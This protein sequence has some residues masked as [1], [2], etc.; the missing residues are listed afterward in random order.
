MPRILNWKW[1]IPQGQS[2]LTIPMFNTIFL[3]KSLEGEYRKALLVHEYTHT[4]Q[5]KRDGQFMFMVKYLLSREHRYLYEIEG[6]QNQIR[7]ILAMDNRK[8]AEQFVMQFVM[9]FAKHLTTSYYLG[10]KFTYEQ[11]VNDIMLGL[12]EQP[13][14][15]DT[16]VAYFDSD[17]VND[18]RYA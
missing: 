11:A 18:I 5:A 6:Y 15:D 7:A 2:A 9:Q 10:K 4:L 14:M 13:L 3:D 1:M 16:V 17:Q 12:V 8:I